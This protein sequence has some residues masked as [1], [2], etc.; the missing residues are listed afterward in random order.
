MCQVNPRVLALALLLYLLVCTMVQQEVRP[1]HERAA[2]VL[3]YIVSYDTA[4]AYALP[5][6]GIVVS[7]FWIT[8]RQATQVMPTQQCQAQVPIH[9]HTR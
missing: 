5:F 1:V 6:V 2:T 9:P 3:S 7:R 8:L 4:A